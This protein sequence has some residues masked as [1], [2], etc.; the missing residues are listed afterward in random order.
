MNFMHMHIETFALAVS[1]LFT[2]SFQFSVLNRQSLKLCPTLP[3]VPDHSPAVSQVLEIESHMPP[4]TFRKKSS[5][6]S[7]FGTPLAYHQIQAI[8]Q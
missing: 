5:W 3:E 2:P 8:D 6:K 4:K 7:H 1:R